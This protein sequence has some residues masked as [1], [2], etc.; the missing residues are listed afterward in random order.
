MWRKAL[1][2]FD[3]TIGT[4]KLGGSRQLGRLDAHDTLLR[5]ASSVC[6]TSARGSKI[7]SAY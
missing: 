6:S 5:L 4:T 7:A 2:R 1:E 3:E